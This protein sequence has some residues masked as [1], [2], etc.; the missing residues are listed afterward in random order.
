ML[1]PIQFLIHA[2]GIK[3]CAWIINLLL[4][5]SVALLI[6][7]LPTAWISINI[8][9]SMYLI[10]TFFLTLKNDQA[11]L[12]KQ[13]NML[14]DDQS[15]S[16]KS[17]KGSLLYISDELQNNVREIFRHSGESNEVV[18][19][20]S[21]SVI[22][23]SRNAEQVA[24][25]TEQQSEATASTAAAV[26]EISQSIEEVTQH[27]HEA[28]SSAQEARTLSV[29]GKNALIPVRKEVQSVA[30]LATE[31]SKTVE[32]LEARSGSVSAMS[33]F[34][35]DLADQTNLLA[36]NAAIE[37]ARAGEHGRGF[38]VVA[39][40]VRALAQ[41]SHNASSEISNDIKAV[42]QQMLDLNHQMS[43]VVESTDN[44][45]RSTVEAE[46]ALQSITT[47]TETVSDQVTQIASAV[48]QQSIAAREI[49]RHIES[50]ALVA[51]SN[52][53]MAKE[54]SSIAGH[55]SILTEK[56]TEGMRSS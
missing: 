43:A 9:V 54:T 21:H 39:E 33:D 26:T 11:R 42:Q 55:I 14:T 44:C 49:S 34:I 24:K 56:T 7:E 1:L 36:L 32:E 8:T 5:S 52:S 46:N 53:S 3:S 47:R 28:Q 22:E 13:I 17:P 16:V 37:A 50:V 20:I 15:E 27:L 6:A 51:E 40:E 18:D 31:T 30:H 29:E 10:T 25:N 12:S 38:S 4:L 19:E 45:V 35:K 23:L 41:R 48:E 2:W